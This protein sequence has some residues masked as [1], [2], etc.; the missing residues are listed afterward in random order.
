MTGGGSLVKNNTGV[1]TLSTPKA[2]T[3]TTAV[4]A[5]VVTVNGTGTLSGTSGLSVASG[6]TLNY[7]PTTVGSALTMGAGSTLSL[8]GGSILGLNWNTSTA[9]KIVAGG[10]ATAG[11]NVKVSMTGA[12][13]SGTTYTIL[14]AAS[15][16]TSGSYTA[17]NNVDYTAVFGQSATAVTITPTSVTPLSAAYW[18]GGTSGYDAV[19]GVA[20]NWTTDGAGTVSGLTPGAAANVYFSDSGAVAGNQVNMTMGANMAL[21]SITINGSLGSPVNTNPVSLSSTGG[22]TLTLTGSGGSG[23]TMNTGAGALTLNPPIVLG[24]AQTWTNNSGNALTVNGAVTN[25]AGT[26]T[27]AGTGNTTINGSLGGGAGG[28]VKTGA[29]VLTMAGVNTYTGTTTVSQGTL[30]LGAAT[31]LPNNNNITVASGA[32]FDFNGQGNSTTRNFNFTISGDGVDGQGAINNTSGT[33]IYGNSSLASLTLAGNASIG[34]NGRWD[35]GDGG[36][37]RTLNGGGFILTKVGTGEITFRPQTVTSLAAVNINSGTLKFEGFDQTTGATAGMTVTTNTGGTLSSYGNRSFNM[38]L[39]FAGGSFANESGTANWSGTVAFNAPSTTINTTQTINLTGVISGSGDI[40]RT[41]GGTVSFGGDTSGYTGNITSSANLVFNRAAGQIINGNITATGALYADVGVLNLASSGSMTASYYVIA[42]SGGTLDFNRSAT[43]T[44]T[45]YLGTDTGT[46]TSTININAGKLITH[47]GSNGMIIGQNTANHNGV[48]N[49]SGTYV[50]NAGNALFGNNQPGATGTLNVNSGGTVTFGVGM[51]TPGASGGG[52]ILGVVLGRDNATAAGTFNLNAGGVLESAKGMIRGTGQG[53][54]NF[55][56]G[57]LRALGST[58]A[59]L[60]VTTTTVNSG[61]AVVDSNGFDVTIVDGLTAGTGSGGLTKNGTGVLTL[62]GANTYAGVTAVNAGSLT[63]S[64]TGTLPA[65]S[66]VNV[67][68]GAQFNYSPS[69]PGTLS[70]AGATLS[71]ASGSTFGTTWGSTIAAAG[72]ASVGGSD[73]GIEMLSG[74]FTSGTP[75]TVLTAASG[76][77]SGAYVLRNNYNYIATIDSSSGTSVILTPTAVAAL[78]TAY[79]KGGLSGQVNV[80]AA[81]DGSSTSNWVGTSG[82]PDQPLTPGSGA[83]VIIS[84]STLNTAPTSTVLGANM[85]IKTLTISDTVN[86]LGL[87]AD[88]YKLT[89]T[90]ASSSAGITVSAGVPAS[91]IGANIGLG[92]NQTWTNN[93]SNPLTVSGG[94]SGS[95]VLTI[96]GTS[97][98][99]LSGANVNT[100][101]VGVINGILSVSSISDSGVSNIGNAGGGGNYFAMVNGTLIYTGTGTQSSSRAVWVDQAQTGSTF[102]ISQASGN[103]TLSN[104]GGT[105]NKNITKTGPGSLTLGGTVNGTMA[106]TVNQ[107]TLTLTGNVIDYSGATTISG[108]RLVLYNNDDT[109]TSGLAVSSGA[110]VEIY[111][112]SGTTYEH[113]AAFT[114]SGAGTLEKTG[115]GPVSMNW[116]QGGTVNM[117]SGALIHVKEG[118]LRLEYGALSNWTN[119]KSDLTVAS[120]AIFDLWD[121]N[122]SGVFVDSLN[123]AGSITRTQNVTGT[124]TIGVDNGSGN[125]SGTISNATGATN[126]TKTGTGTQTL[127]GSNSSY[128]GATTIQDGLLIVSGGGGIGDGSNVTLSSVNTGAGL[129]LDASEIINSLAGGSATAGG[130]NLQGNTLRMGQSGTA[131]NASYAGILS[132]TGG[133]ERRGTGTQTLTANN[134]FSGGVRVTGADTTLAVPSIGAIG[135][136]QPLGQGASPIQLQGGTLAITGAGSYTTNRGLELYSP[137]SESGTL[138]VTGTLNMTGDLTG[139]SSGSTFTKAGAGTFNYSGTGSWN[140]NLNITGGAFELTGGGSIPGIGVTTLSTAGTSLKINTTGTMQTTRV[141]IA[142]GTT[143][144]LEAGTLRLAGGVLGGSPVY[145]IDN[146][147][148]FNWGNGTLAVYGSNTTGVT[149]RSAP[150]GAVTGPAVKEGNYLFVNGSLSQ[151]AGTKLDLGSSFLAD[152]GVRYNQI[153]VTGSLSIA[154]GATMSFGLNPYFMRPFGYTEDWGTLVLAYAPGGITGSYAFGDLTG[155]SSD[156]IGWTRLGDQIDS[157][158]DPALLTRNTYQIE[159][160]TGSGAGY[161]FTQGG[162]AILLHYKLSGTVPEPASAGL[163]IAGMALLRVIANRRK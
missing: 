83:D 162:G 97:P 154:S 59:F 86:G 48:L 152:G 141:T 135:V 91:S 9:S 10:A 144:S 113:R 131:S 99:V 136:A 87:N 24:N 106:L 118:T 126:L 145:S 42:R 30:R 140:A 142:A 138:N 5:G 55:N 139:G 151:P 63:I 12:Y 105:I 17:I 54:F 125:F 58:T 72:A 121:N 110:T 8:A 155:I 122:N 78:T 158:Q 148:S 143:V 11:S 161:N 111:R 60:D 107:G 26:L 7:L 75:Y 119:N 2:Y 51:N 156:G 132:G 109:W 80:W 112:D 45:G 21:N 89:I 1:L 94:L 33:A 49:V 50:Q 128:S 43:L 114:L 134:T 115:N 20:S 35:I 102:N 6:A 127:S 137:S 92:A 133:I 117:S 100:A 70:L 65:S 38:P 147:G 146:G 101:G 90:P 123:G 73:V 96:A 79:W 66:A 124:L 40:N 120:G 104:S 69:S 95:G 28:L 160:R 149:D 85:G 67:A 71:L 23:L 68:D 52:G 64:G 39:V 150:G 82:G 32:T 153:Q 3:G 36:A 44:G 47:N 13:T 57:T 27:V 46:G 93:S 56:G 157:F 129:R 74:S 98:V 16:L 37:G 159:Y 130:V 25:G 108:G 29:G 22:H 84:N 116:D 88:G 18:K 19:L 41:G 31:G 61:G 4:N 81:S 53:Y 34:T 15:G 62:S 163:L 77:T 14:Q 103:L 76:L